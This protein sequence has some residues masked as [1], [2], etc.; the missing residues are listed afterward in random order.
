[1]V[2]TTTKKVYKAKKIISSL[3]LGVLQSKNV[4]FEPPLSQEYQD[5]IDNIGIGVFNKLI[6]CFDKSFWGNRTGWLHLVT[7]EGRSKYPELLILPDTDKFM[8]G[9]EVSGEVSR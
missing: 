5:S 4:I 9:V 6:V 8:I 1:M 3:P 2:L 7:S